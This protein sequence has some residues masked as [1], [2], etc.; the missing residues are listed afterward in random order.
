MSVSTSKPSVFAQWQQDHEALAMLEG[1]LASVLATVRVWQE[2][3]PDSEEMDGFIAGW[4]EVM[5][6]VY[7]LV[8]SGIRHGELMRRF[9]ADCEDEGLSVVLELINRMEAEAR[10]PVAGMT[11]AEFDAIV[12]P[13]PGGRHEPCDADMRRSF[14]RAEQPSW[15]TRI[16]LI[17]A[18]AL[19]QQHMP[20]LEALAARGYI[21]LFDL[22]ADGAE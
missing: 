10:P 5:N 4:T 17:I 20:T 21:D 8:S 2:H 9:I 11:E 13:P 7:D 18:D 1:E 19:E 6:P 16:K 22:L 3:P 14:T 12:P 15:E